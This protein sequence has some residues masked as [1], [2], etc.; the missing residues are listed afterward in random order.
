MSVETKNNYIIRSAS[1]NYE[2]NLANSKITSL[3]NNNITIDSN[4][5][6]LSESTSNYYLHKLSIGNCSEQ[7]QDWFCIPNFHNNNKY[8]MYPNTNNMDV[9]VCFKYCDSQDANAKAVE[10]KDDSVYIPNNTKCTL[11]E[12]ENDLIYNPLAIIAII[13]THF[14]INIPESALNIKDNYHT[15]TETLG[16]RGSYLNDLWRVNRNGRAMERSDITTLMSKSYVDIDKEAT[17]NQNKLLMKIIYK[18]RTY[19]INNTSIKVINK[20]INNAYYRL[21]GKNDNGKRYYIQNKE[22]KNNFLKKI[23]NYVFDIEALDKIYGR[24][25]NGDKKLINIIAYAY[26][27]MKLVCFNNNKPPTNND[28]N[29]N[30]IK[31]NIKNIRIYK[32]IRFEEKS[33]AEEL[34]FITQMFKYA[35]FNC[36]NTNYDKFEQYIKDKMGNIEELN[37][38][39]TKNT[40]EPIDCPFGKLAKLDLSNDNTIVIKSIY[41]YYNIIEEYNHNVMYEY[42]ENTANINKILLVFSIFI[43]LVCA[44]SIFYGFLDICNVV[45]YIIYLVN[46]CHIFYEWLSLGVLG[47]FFCKYYCLLFCKNSNSYSFSSIIANILNILLIMFAFGM[48]YYAVIELLNIDYISLLQKIDTTQLPNSL[49]SDADQSESDAFKYMFM[50]IIIVYILSIFFYSIYIVRYSLSAHEYD[51]IG[52]KDADY[53]ISIQ[54]VD[55]ILIK[56]YIEGLMS[57]YTKIYSHLFDKSDVSEMVVNNDVG[58]LPVNGVNTGTDV[59]VNNVSPLTEPLDTIVS[60]TAHAFGLPGVEQQTVQN[61]SGEMAARIARH[62]NNGDGID[63]TDLQAELEKRLGIGRGIGRY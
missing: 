25:K 27:I 59:P 28:N 37:S 56:T 6:S 52:N 26:N 20:D 43:A 5:I 41:D 45:H 23:K 63:E 38:F 36:F 2:I 19:G 18:Y 3:N 16:L 17:T 31:E 55:Y 62:N 46:F 34:D 8:S 58:G 40:W 53:K 30:E 42:A 49:Y 12:D 47:T 50:Y 21:L 35:C 44:I 32:N 51:I 24:D 61:M 39:N 4:H 14:N 57:K 7:W 13:G 15:F 10:A 9:G 11:Y 22:F 60:N 1:L 48:L 29:K 33:E 54:F